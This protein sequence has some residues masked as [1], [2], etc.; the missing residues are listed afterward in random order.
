MGEEKVLITGG[1]GYLGS[2]LTNHLLEKDYEVTCLDN[3]RYRQKS[4]F[5]F[6][7]NPNF[8]FVYG[9]ARDSTLIKKLVP[10]F[11]VVIP[12]A[13]IVGVPACDRYPEDAKSINLESI[14]MLNRIRS[15]N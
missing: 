3:L 4:L 6:V 13:A 14:T 2:V 1:A 15:S 9:D 8:E 5:G 12:L 7:G 10:S 11:D